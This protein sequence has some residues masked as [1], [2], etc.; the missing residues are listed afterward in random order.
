M[1]AIFLDKGYIDVMKQLG[2]DVSPPASVINLNFK[3]FPSNLRPNF[4]LLSIT[5]TLQF[6]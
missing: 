3:H 2:V 4:V 6:F 5:K 1:W